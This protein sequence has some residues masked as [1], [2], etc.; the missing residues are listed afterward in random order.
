MPLISIP[1]GEDVDYEFLNGRFKEG[2]AAISN[3]IV[4]I[5][6]TPRIV[7]VAGNTMVMNAT[8][9]EIIIGTLIAE[10]NKGKI[11][12]NGFGSFWSFVKQEVNATLGKIETELQFLAP[13]CEGGNTST[14][15][16]GLTCS[17][18]VCNY[19]NGVIGSGLQEVE[20][21]CQK[22]KSCML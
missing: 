21:V 22:E 1:D 9:A 5:L 4:K 3:S 18:C 7:T 8:N 15:T 17:K 16:V 13:A 12:L 10:A 6:N 14:A 11:D 19:R 2:L 20:E